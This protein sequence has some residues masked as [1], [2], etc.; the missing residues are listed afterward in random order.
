[1][2]RIA[3]YG[4]AGIGDNYK[5]GGQLSSVLGLK[6]PSSGTGTAS[7]Y[8]SQNIKRWGCVQLTGPCLVLCRHLYYTPPVQFLP[9]CCLISYRKFKFRYMEL[10]DLSWEGLMCRK[11]RYLEISS[12]RYVVLSSCSSPSHCLPV[13]F[14]FFAD[15][16]ICFFDVGF[17]YRNHIYRF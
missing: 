12:F 8:G 10:F 11:F 15:E 6:L 3:R 9:Y 2:A 13:F 7:K 16:E 17:D 5:T 14:F 1:M 4:V